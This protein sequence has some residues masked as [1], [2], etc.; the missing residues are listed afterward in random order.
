MRAI[1]SRGRV[2]A[3]ALA[4]AALAGLAFHAVAGGQGTTPAP[5]RARLE[6]TRAALFAQCIA[7]SSEI[8]PLATRAA[9]RHAADA[10]SAI[11]PHTV[12]YAAILPSGAADEF[13][14]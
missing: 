1:R 7:G 13:A 5:A 14:D 11:A 2:A 12:C 6:P 8:A 10:P 3:G 9:R 4:L